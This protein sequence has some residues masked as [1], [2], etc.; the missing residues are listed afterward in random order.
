MK[1]I[2][3]NLPDSYIKSLQE[4]VLCS[5]GRRSEYLRVAIRDLI[6][7]ERRL[8]EK[9]EK[10][11]EERKITRFFDYCIN[12]ERKLDN[13]ARRNHFFHKNIEVFE[14]RF[15]C[16][17]HKQFKDKSFDEFPAHLIDRIQKKLKAYK[18]HMNGS[19]VDEVD[20]ENPS[21]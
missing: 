9:E 14:L 12:C 11:I 2:K 13:T 19:N 8:S 18:K 20:S 3:I 15:C 6:V 16:S 1:I 17:C 5:G 21:S 10:E 7:N 4:A